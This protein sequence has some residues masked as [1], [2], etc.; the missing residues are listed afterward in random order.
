MALSWRGVLLDGL[1]RVKIQ[2]YSRSMTRRPE[3]RMANPLS[4]PAEVS[5]TLLLLPET[6]TKE[7]DTFTI[8]PACADVAALS[9]SVVNTLLFHTAQCP[10]YCRRCR[11]VTKSAF[12]PTT[13]SGATSLVPG[14]GG[15]PPV[16]SPLGADSD[17][18][19][20]GGCRVNQRRSST[21]LGMATSLTAL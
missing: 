18:A 8:A 10:R 11:L 7:T 21:S 20:T 16:A 2:E 15:W 1:R 13:R 12:R 14:C 4:K 6:E 5:R 19:A 3:L 9:I 17:Y